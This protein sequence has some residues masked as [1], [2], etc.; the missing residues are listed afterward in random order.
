MNALIRFP[1][2][3]TA[4]SELIDDF[5]GS[6][7]LSRPNRELVATRWPE[8]DVVEDEKSYLLRADMPGLE[9]KD[10]SVTVENGVLSIS[11]EKKEERKEQKDGRFTYYERSYGKFNRSF[12]LP[13]HVDAEHIEANYKNGVLELKINKT[14]KAKPKEIEVK[15]E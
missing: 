10:I 13:E 9:K 12:N 5:F 6:T 14:E 3:A 11:G 1:N 7:E 8:V 2:P 4:L 15:I